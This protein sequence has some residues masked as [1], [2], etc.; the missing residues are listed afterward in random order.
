[1]SQ[2]DD[3]ITI[4]TRLQEAFNIVADEYDFAAGEGI[5]VEWGSFSGVPA[6]TIQLVCPE[7]TGGQ[8]KWLVKVKLQAVQALLANYSS[9][10]PVRSIR[11]MWPVPVPLPA[12]TPQAPPP[13]PVIIPPLPPTTPPT[14]NDRSYYV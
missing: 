6:N 8:V 9:T 4:R 5:S 7:D 2:Y 13:P 14:S 3:W 10:C 12:G 11:M 1:M